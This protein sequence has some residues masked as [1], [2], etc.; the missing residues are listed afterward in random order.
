MGMARDMGYDGKPFIWDEEERR[1][2]RARLDAIYFLLY[3]ID[4]E[5]AA[6]VLD[7]FPIVREHDEHEFAR[8]RTKDMILAY[9]SAFEAGDIETRVAV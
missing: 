5:D 7:T 9:M 6:Y 1:H 2:S 8:Y 3:G 4:R